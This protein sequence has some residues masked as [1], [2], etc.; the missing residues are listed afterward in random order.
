M[1]KAKNKRKAAEAQQ[2]R[3]EFY[4][5]VYAEAEAQTEVKFKMEHNRLG[6]ECAVARASA[7][8]AAESTKAKCSKVVA[9]LED[10]LRVAIKAQRNES[11]QVRYYQDFLINELERLKEEMANRNT[12]DDGDA[13]IDVDVGGFKFRDDGKANKWPYMFRLRVMKLLMIGISP[14]QIG[15]TVQSVLREADCAAL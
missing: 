4:K 10:N 11:E 6:A 14:S 1:A 2:Q 13:R 3:W 12:G 8:K 15:P 5:D 9:D 7:A